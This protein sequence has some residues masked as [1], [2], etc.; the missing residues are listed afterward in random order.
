MEDDELSLDEGL[1]RW[2]NLKPTKTGLPFVVFITSENPLSPDPFITL[3]RSPNFQDAFATFTITDPIGL[4]SGVLIG[5]NVDKVEAWVKKNQSVLI[6]Y[7]D[8]T[9][10]YTDDVMEKLVSVD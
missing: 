5:P 2:A 9:I 3:S 6:G 1:Y 4:A 8:G 10:P 7:W